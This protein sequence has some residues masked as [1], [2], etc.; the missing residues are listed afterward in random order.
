MPEEQ[1]VLGNV[2]QAAIHGGSRELHPHERA[3]YAER[4]P[5][6]SPR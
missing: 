5:H 2:R 1:A 3:H 4:G 6:A